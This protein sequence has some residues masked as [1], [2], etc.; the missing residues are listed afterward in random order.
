MN[1]LKT[2]EPTPGV[3][4]LEED[5]DFNEDEE[6][7]SNNRAQNLSVFSTTKSRFK[8]LKQGEPYITSV[9]DKSKMSKQTYSVINSVRNYN[10]S[11]MGISDN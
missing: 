11:T 10:K 6:Q 5:Q 9:S 7:S 2:I 3:N 8:I 1:I 4:V